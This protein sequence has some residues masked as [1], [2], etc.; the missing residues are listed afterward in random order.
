MGNALRASSDSLLRD[1]TELQALEQEKRHTDPDSPRLVRLAEEIEALALR[2]MGTSIRQRERAEAIVE[3][4]GST[5]PDQSIAETPREIH[6]ILTEWRDTER[7]LSEAVPDSP[8]ADIAER[9]IEVLRMEYRRA[10]DAA[11]RRGD[12]GRGTPP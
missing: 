1:L 7:Q 11:R 10:H 4:D 12:E 6:V 9:R 8:E 2:V 3:V 5:T